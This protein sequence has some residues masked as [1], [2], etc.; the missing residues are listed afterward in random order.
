M[1]LGRSF[2]VTGR[3][4]LLCTNHITFGDECL[5]SRYLLIMDT[6]WHK[7]ILKIN[8]MILNFPRH[9]SVGNHVWIV[10]PNSIISHNINKEYQRKYN[11][12]TAYKKGKVDKVV[13]YSPRD[14]DNDFY[15]DNKVI[16]IIDVVPVCGYGNLML[17]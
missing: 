13:E 11:T 9:I 6:D 17:Y 15:Q 7:V 2:N 8:K 16:L 10:V 1:N 4:L 3:S 14:I 12:K 5:L